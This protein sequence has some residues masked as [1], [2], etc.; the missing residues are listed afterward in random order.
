MRHMRNFI[1]LGFFSIL[2]AFS[3]LTLGCPSKSNPT[4]TNSGPTSTQT[5]TATPTSTA[6]QT[7]S[8]TPTSTVD[9]SFPAQGFEGASVPA[10]WYST[11]P[12]ICSL[13]AL[14]SAQA[15]SG[16]Q[17]AFNT[18]AFT[19]A[20]QVG[21][22][23]EFLNPACNFTGKT[24]SFWY[25]LTQLPAATGTEAIVGGDSIYG[26]SDSLLA[27]VTTGAWTQATWA[28]TYSM[29]GCDPS[30]VNGIEFVI[31][32]RST[33]TGPFNTVTLYID[34]VTVQ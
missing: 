8:A 28:F 18:I 17:S 32:T 14:S 3:Y 7:A 31:G 9:A 1:Y 22:M 24:L 33:A 10:G 21:G 29:G 13:L 26:D 34:D 4:S 23:V 30:A 15:H 19:G 20:N 5:P 25:Y 16:S 12:A 11:T 2:I 6:T 27:T